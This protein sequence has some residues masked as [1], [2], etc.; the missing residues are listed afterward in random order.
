MFRSL[1]DVLS[2]EIDN[3]DIPKILKSQDSE[4]EKFVIGI[5]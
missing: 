2:I 3:K 5:K 1:S 4:K